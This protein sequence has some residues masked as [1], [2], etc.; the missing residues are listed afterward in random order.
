MRSS[1][2]SGSRPAA[3]AEKRVVLHGLAPADS[4]AARPVAAGLSGQRI[5]L[6][7]PANAG[8]RRA[9]MLLSGKAQFGLAQKLRTDGATIGEI[10]SFMS[11]LYFR[12]KLEY[13]R[14]F[15]NPPSGLPGILVITPGDGILPADAVIS[16][17]FLIRMAA[18]RV[19]HQ[20]DVY[21]SALVRDAAALHEKL[22][23]GVPVILLGS[24]ATQKYL[25]PLVPIFGERLV[26]PSKFLGMGNMQRG[27]VL[28]RAC[29]AGQELEYC[30]VA[31]ATT[32]LAA[33]KAR[34]K[35]RKKKKRISPAE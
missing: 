28:L 25:D 33:D 35:T 4:F 31:I 29:R 2:Q 21:R 8:G 34:S 9:K 14:T 19:H 5:F 15:A 10:F 1:S 13:A 12:G 17:D 30:A 11:A 20:D 22:A 6:L 24:L 3:P 27:G 18:T 7:S 16:H 26:F 32:K 23:A